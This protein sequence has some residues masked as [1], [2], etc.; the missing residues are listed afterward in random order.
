M[1]DFTSADALLLLEA[2]PFAA[3]CVN[4]AGVVVFANQA[5]CDMAGGGPALV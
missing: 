1:T 5:A 3:L 4:A 2:V